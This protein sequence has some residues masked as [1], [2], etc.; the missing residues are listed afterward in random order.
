MF[1]MTISKTCTR[2]YDLRLDIRNR[3][4]ETPK[5]YLY[6]FTQ[7]LYIYTNTLKDILTYKVGSYKCLLKM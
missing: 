6:I 1:E 4:L 2:H 3:Y 5:R 7:C